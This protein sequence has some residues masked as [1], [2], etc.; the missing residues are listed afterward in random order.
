LGNHPLAAAYYGAALKD[1]WIGGGADIT[2]D[3]RSTHQW[4]KVLNVR[5]TDTPKPTLSQRHPLLDIPIDRKNILGSIPHDHYICI[6]STVTWAIGR[7]Q[8]LD[9]EGG[10]SQEKVMKKVLDQCC[11]SISNISYTDMG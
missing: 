8:A 7:A 11:E 6:P 5:L 4:G 3:S 2:G 9:G 1:G 10:D